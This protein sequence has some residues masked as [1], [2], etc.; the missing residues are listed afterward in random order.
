MKRMSRFERE[1]NGELGD[2]WKKDALS[3]IADIE[4]DYETGHLIIEDG[5]AKWDTNG[6]YLMQDIME[7]LL[8]SK[9]ADL[10]DLEHHEAMRD[11]QV[12]EEINAYKERM[13]NHVYDEEE[14]AEMRS[15]FGAGTEIVNVFTGDTITL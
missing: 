13:K 6:S 4:K 3:K 9:Y 11:A 5:A 10:I 2:Y 15:A 8:H 12:T 14:L 7:V 1:L